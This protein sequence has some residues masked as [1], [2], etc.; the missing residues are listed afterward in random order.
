MDTSQNEEYKVKRRTYR[1]EKKKA[2]SEMS[3]AFRD[4]SIIVLAE[5]LKVRGTLK[6][7]SRL[8]CI[9]KPG[10]LILY[11]SPK[12]KVGPSLFFF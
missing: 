6:G 10:L 7:W 3:S 11:K 12:A 2:I 5:W 9:L 4:S 1:R 8:W